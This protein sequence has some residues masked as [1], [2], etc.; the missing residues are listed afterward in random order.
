MRTWV[1]LRTPPHAAMPSDRR[2][3]P[4]DRGQFPVGR[5]PRKGGHPA[6]LFLGFV[7]ER[8]HALCQTLLHLVGVG[9]G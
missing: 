8:E 2:L 4:A 1:S 5:E 3:Q 6:P 9:F 7:L